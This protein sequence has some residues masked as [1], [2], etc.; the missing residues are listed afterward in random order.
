MGQGMQRLIILL[1]LIFCTSSVEAQTTVTV[2]NLLKECVIIAKQNIRKDNN[3]LLL[4]IELQWIKSTTGH[5]GCK[6]AVSSYTVRE[7]PVEKNIPIKHNWGKFVMTKNS[8]QITLPITA[9]SHNTS[10]H[11]E[12]GCSQPD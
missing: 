3:L 9:L 5:C 12:L 8:G 4:D 7:E 11:M 1:S 2:N 6:S 10:Y